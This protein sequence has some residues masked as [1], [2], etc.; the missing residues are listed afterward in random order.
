MNFAT[1]TSQ[2][3]EW[4]SKFPKDKQYIEN[5]E[6]KIDNQ[7]AL[8]K[9]IASS[10]SLKIEKIS[11]FHYNFYAK[12][13]NLEDKFEKVFLKLTEK[14]EINH[15]VNFYYNISNRL[16]FFFPSFFPFFYAYDANSSTLYFEKVKTTTTTSVSSSYPVFT[17]KDFILDES[18]SENKEKTLQS[19]YKVIFHHL[20]IMSVFFSF[21][22][23]NLKT[24]D[25][26]LIPCPKFKNYFINTVCD[27]NKSINELYHHTD[28]EEIDYAI[29]LNI[30]SENIRNCFFKAN[31]KNFC[32]VSKNEIKVNLKNNLI[33]IDRTNIL[34]DIFSLL[35][36]SLYV[37]YF[38]SGSFLSEN[39]FRYFITDVN[40]ENINKI[41]NFLEVG[42]HHLSFDLFIKNLPSN[43]EKT[44][45]SPPK[46]KI[47]SHDKMLDFIEMYHNEMYK[48][49]E[50]YISTLEN[51]V[52]DFNSSYFY[53][54]LIEFKDEISRS[55]ITE[56]YYYIKLNF[57]IFCKLKNYFFQEDEEEKNSF[58]NIQKIFK[59][60][61]ISVYDIIK[62]NGQLSKSK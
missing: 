15:I 21:C 52:K 40:T 6:K 54:N 49:E 24:E 2:L 34:T 62:N 4:K 26:L 46:I 28:Y 27:E 51:Y 43:E 3:K 59:E 11:Y 23:Y 57:Y 17:L 30:F 50:F 7:I 42:N 13:K 33:K 56:F 48:E 10:S 47:T 8:E 61:L 55:E 36:D 35:K 18:K 12:N 41:D 22:H 29:T 45:F 1:Y 5:I 14:E 37:S 25:F 58:I 20:H 44:Q 53:K 19:I 16:N 31:Q 60:N 39:L 32:F 38:P 9:E